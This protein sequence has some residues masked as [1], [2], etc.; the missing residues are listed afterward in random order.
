MIYDMRANSTNKNTS[1]PLLKLTYTEYISLPVTKRTKKVTKG[2]TEGKSRMK[3]DNAFVVFQKY[4][5]YHFL[6]SQGYNLPL[7]E[8]SV[9]ATAFWKYLNPVK[10]KSATKTTSQSFNAL[11]NSADLDLIKKVISLV[12]KKPCQPSNKFSSSVPSATTIPCEEHNLSYIV[13]D[14]N[15]RCPKHSIYNLLCKKCKPSETKYDDKWFE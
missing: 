13:N 9:F 2:N 8:E 7:K 12:D 1:P 11:S 3:R 10:K 15:S 14:A 4:L 5:H 6:E